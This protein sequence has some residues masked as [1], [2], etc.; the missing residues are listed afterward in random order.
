MMVMNRLLAGLVVLAG[1]L[2][3][4]WP[5]KHGSLAV[6]L[7][8]QEQEMWCWAAAG[9]MIMEYFG[10]EHSQCEQA[11]ALFGRQDC[12]CNQCSAPIGAPPCNKDGW[13]QFRRYGFDFAKTTDAALSW[14]EVKR[15]LS[16][17]CSC[18]KS[19]F[20]VSWH[21]QGGG[22]HI[23][24]ANGYQEDGDREGLV[25]AIDPLPHCTG[26]QGPHFAD[27]VGLFFDEYV[28]GPADW[29]SG[30]WDDYYDI[31]YTGS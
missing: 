29:Y 3:C 31:T 26:N 17:R 27:H 8:P 6:A 7:R 20:M 16:S 13:P 1:T 14:S 25:W 19:P 30:H 4:C 28:Q 21:L 15:Q 10:R 9:Q 24:V 5:G 12:P 18:K 23:V 22:G 2:G 11:N